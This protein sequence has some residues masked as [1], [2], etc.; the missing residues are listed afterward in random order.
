MKIMSMA[1][2][3]QPNLASEKDCAKRA[4]DIAE[5]MKAA[6]AEINANVAVLIADIEA[7]PRYNR[8]VAELEW[9]GAVI[10]TVAECAKLAVK[11]INN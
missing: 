7:H 10:D 6:Q 1:A 4:A 8:H 2:V 9:I 11:K 3:D 5:R